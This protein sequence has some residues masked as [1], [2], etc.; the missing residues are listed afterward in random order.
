[1]DTTGVLRKYK[2][3]ELGGVRHGGILSVTS[4]RASSPLGTMSLGGCGVDASAGGASHT[5]VFGMCAIKAK[6]VPFVA[7]VSNFSSASDMLRT[8]PGTRRGGQL[9]KKD[10]KAAGY[11]GRVE[12]PPPGIM[13]TPPGTVTP[14][15]G[16]EEAKFTERSLF[17]L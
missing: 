17:G 8:G 3:A 5:P 2:M 13:E 6:T 4:T 12:T 16:L 11:R 9:R 14:A 7:F 15:P 10:S 1:L